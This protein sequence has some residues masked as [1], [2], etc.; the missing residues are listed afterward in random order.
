LGW[1]GK[2]ALIG[3]GPFV[4]IGLFSMGAALPRLRAD[5]DGTANAT[6]MVQ[7]IGAIVAPVFAAASPLAGRLINRWGIRRVYLMAVLLMAVGGAGPAVCNSL[8]VIVGCRVVLALG[9]A[10][11]FTAGM[12][13]IARLPEKQR[14]SILGLNAFA[15]GA[16]LMPLFPFIGALAQHSWRAAFL[17]HL[18]LLPMLILALKLPADD[19]TPENAIPDPQ[20][21]R[22]GLLAGVHPALAIAAA[23]TGLPIVAC[24][25]YSPFLLAS[26]G[27]A[28]PARI[29]Q[30]LGIMTLFSLAGSGSYPLLHKLLGTGGLIKL[31]LA[32]ITAGCLVLGRA[33]D[34]PVAMAGMG[35]LAI[36]VAF[37]ASVI[38]AAT[39]ENLRPGGSI[40]AAMGV[41]TF[42]MYGSQM[43][44]PLLS[45]LLGSVAGPAAVFLAL[46][47]TTGAMLG[48]VAIFYPR[49][50]G[51]HVPA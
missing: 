7:L 21:R 2:G 29:G 33:H 19:G 51:D 48:I 31:A 16:I 27:I 8:A 23:F 24:S 28:D 18:I 39:I 12:S 47:A 15:G 36:G 37:F 42:C 1:I 46:A 17:V 41:V 9:V 14:A 20:G 5:F 35:T 4:S 45:G 50:Q 11:G 43:A 13:G 25:M 30:F 38:Y 6:T 22:V 3:I 32:A 40:P 34:A 44:F 49:A 26:I 10:S